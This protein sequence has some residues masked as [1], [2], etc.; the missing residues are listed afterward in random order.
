MDECGHDSDGLCY[1]TLNS[2]YSRMIVHYNGTLMPPVM[3]STTTRVHL[4][5]VQTDR[6]TTTVDDS[7]QFDVE[8]HLGVRWH[9]PTV[10]RRRR[11]DR[12]RV[13]A[14]SSVPPLLR[15]RRYHF[16][17]HYRYRVIDSVW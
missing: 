4:L 7:V 13:G 10:I 16:V 15:H 14:L 6:R 17:R 1:T 8:R 11:L 5:R 12:R 2:R 3:R 9:V